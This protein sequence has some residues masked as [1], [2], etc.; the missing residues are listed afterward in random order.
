M[1]DRRVRAAAR[2]LLDYVG[3]RLATRGVRANHVTFA[4]WTI[5]VAACVAAAN[6]DWA[7]ALLLWL[8][9]RLFDGLDGALARQVG[10]TNLGGYL[11][12][13]AD[14]SIYA[15]FIAGVALALPSTRLAGLFLLVTY[16]LSATALL[17]GSSLIDRLGVAREDER[18]LRFLGGL[19]EGLETTVAYVLIT[20]LPAYAATIEWIFSLMVLIT[21][22]QR[23]LFTTDVLRTGSPSAPRHER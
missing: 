5:G 23:V 6:R 10:A 9:N 7:L 18:S 22:G 20:V 12:L 21:A 1:L 8:V 3:E 16:Y 15:G 2:P 14:F 11:D 13:V 17:A 19:A 4:G